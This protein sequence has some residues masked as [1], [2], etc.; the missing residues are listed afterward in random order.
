MSYAFKL[1]NKKITGFYFLFFSFF[2]LIF[3]NVLSNSPDNP[4]PPPAL[5]N[6]Q[7]CIDPPYPDV[8]NPR[9]PIFSWT[10]SGNPQVQYWLQVDNNSDFSSPEINRNVVSGDH[11]YQTPPNLLPRRTTYWYKIAV[12]DAYGWTGWTGCNSFYLPG[13]PPNPPTNLR[14]TQPDYCVSPPGATF[15]WTFTDDDQPND[16]QSAYQVQVYTR[17]GFYYQRDGIYFGYLSPRCPCD[18][19][20]T[21][22]DCPTTFPTSPSD[23]NVCYDWYRLVFLGSRSVRYDKTSG[24][25]V[26]YDSGKVSSPSNS[27]AVNSGLSYN[28]TYY[29]RVRVWDQDDKVSDWAEGPSFTTPKHPYPTADFTWNPPQPFVNQIVQ[30]T[31]RSIAY[32][33]ATITSWSWTFQDGIP[34]TSNQQNPQVKFT[35]MG[36]K[37]VTLSVTD[38]D[39]YGPCTTTKTIN[40]RK[41]LPKWELMKNLDSNFFASLLVSLKKQILIFFENLIEFKNKFLTFLK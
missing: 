15:Y 3:Q 29:W 11:S 23:P 16:S 19:N 12:K 41:P 34:S 9:Q 31:D 8:S 27:H 32:G 22:Q 1:K 13:V 7:V 4:Y 17:E 10:T 6:I 36:E 33:G 20:S 24:E 30:F 39:G 14:V 21:T 40:V 37:T 38:S 25:V 26:V 35:S 18:I 2:I 5:V 28:T